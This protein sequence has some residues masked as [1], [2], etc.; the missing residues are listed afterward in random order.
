MK[1]GVCWHL[2]LLIHPV[3][4]EPHTFMG[5]HNSDPYFD[6]TPIF[7]GK[8]GAATLRGD[9]GISASTVYSC[10]HTF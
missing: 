7:N 3:E 5:L 9:G 4:Y 1:I 8:K 6:L 2:E 10:S